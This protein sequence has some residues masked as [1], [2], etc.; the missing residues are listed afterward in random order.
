[1]AVPIVSWSEELRACMDNDLPAL[2]DHGQKGPAVALL[3]QDHG[4]HLGEECHASADDNPMP[5]YHERGTATSPTN[6]HSQSISFMARCSRGGR[7]NHSG[8]GEIRG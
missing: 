4:G 3:R 8:R 2:W 5:S 1:M 6:S 7:R